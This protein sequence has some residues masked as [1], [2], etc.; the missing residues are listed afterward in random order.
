MDKYK[1]LNELKEKYGDQFIEE[2]ASLVLDSGV[3]DCFRCYNYCKNRPCIEAIKLMLI[4][5]LGG[6]FND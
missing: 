4:D 5:I 1:L 3:G 6:K 2:L